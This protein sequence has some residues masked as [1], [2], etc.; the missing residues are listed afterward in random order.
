M[1]LLAFISLST[2][3]LAIIFVIAIASSVCVL[4]AFVVGE[5]NFGWDFNFSASPRPRVPASAYS[6]PHPFF[7]SP[8][9][10]KNDLHHGSILVN[11]CCILQSL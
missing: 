10:G 9:C 6:F 1:I 8:L 2:S 3:Y 5:R 11:C 7:R 4:C